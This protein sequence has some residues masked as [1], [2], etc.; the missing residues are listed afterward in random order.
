MYNKNKWL[1]K[2]GSAILNLVVC[3]LVLGLILVKQHF[4]GRG[5]TYAFLFWS[6]PLAISIAIVGD[7]ILNLLGSNRAYVRLGIMLIAAALAYGWVWLVYLVLGPWINTFSFPVFYLWLIGN[8]AQLIFL[9]WV[10]PPPVKRLKTTKRFA[11]LL[12]IPVV[13]VSTVALLIGLSMATSYFNRPE[14]ELY[15]IPIGFKGRFRVIYGQECGISPLYEQGRRVL[16]IPDDG[17][18]IIKPTFKAGL[19]DN[20]YYLVNKSGRRQRARELLGYREAKTKTPGILLSRTGS[21]GGP[22]PDGSSS[23]E[24]PLA[25]HY[26]DFEVFTKDTA[27]ISDQVASRQEQTFDSLMTAKVDACRNMHPKVSR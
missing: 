26:S 3:L 2:T 8:Y 15:L 7:T 6:A 22:M 24:S 4:F 23:S 12:L 21:L 16:Q 14:K 20:Q 25:I 17:I 9:N 1:I 13:A 5:D 19:I 27:V 18:L 11:S 10:L